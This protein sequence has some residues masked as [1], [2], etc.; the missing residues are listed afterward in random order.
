MDKLPEL[1][2]VKI[3]CSAS[4]CENDKHAYRPKRGQWKALPDEG[5]CQSCGDTSVDMTVTRARDGSNREAIFHELGREFIRDHFLNKPFDERARRLIR[6]YGMDGI[7]ERAPSRVASAIGKKPSAWD[8]RQTKFE[9]N[10]LFYAQH[11]TATCCRRCAWYWYGIPREG[12]LS[13]EDLA[14]CTS[15][16]QAYLDRREGEIRAIAASAED[17]E[18]DGK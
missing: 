11:A 16:V 2:K 10:V 6:R 9:G 4:D 12:P 1:E 3:S 14:F 18:T 15:L 7:R 8:G 13:A 17:D 5:V